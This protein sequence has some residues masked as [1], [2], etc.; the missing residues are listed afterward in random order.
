MGLARHMGYTFRSV[1]P[2]PELMAMAERVAARLQD[3]VQR[4]CGVRCSEEMSTG[5][6]AES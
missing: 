5:S 2:M 1:V 3:L 6:S 4:V